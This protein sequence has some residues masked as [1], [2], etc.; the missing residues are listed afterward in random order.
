MLFLQLMLIVHWMNLDTQMY[1]TSSTIYIQHV[2]TFIMR[3]I[4]HHTYIM[5]YILDHSKVLMISHEL[6]ISVGA[7]RSQFVTQDWAWVIQLSLAAIIS[8]KTNSQVI[9]TSCDTCQVRFQSPCILYFTPIL[10]KQ[11]S[12]GWISVEMCRRMPR[13]QNHHHTLQA[14]WCCSKASYNIHAHMHAKLVVCWDIQL[15][16]YHNCYIAIPTCITL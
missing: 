15:A 10:A 4:T 9:P 3:S 13:S 1:C 7:H 12:L 8:A 6:M 2:I 5:L 16:I 11:L 14:A